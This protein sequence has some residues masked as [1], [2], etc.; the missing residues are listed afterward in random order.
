MKIS[1]FL[2]S[3]MG[4]DARE[5]DWPAQLH[6]FTYLERSARMAVA[7]II[8]PLVERVVTIELSDKLYQLALKRFS[9][10]PAVECRHGDSGEILGRVL[11]ELN[12]PA[13]LWLDGH[14]SGGVTALLMKRMER[15]LS[16]SGH[17]GARSD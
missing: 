14:W 1:I 17:S 6:A 3:P 12:A 11:A 8:A 2:V 5:I 10:T 15:K 13:L 7:A 16:C 9:D 4:G